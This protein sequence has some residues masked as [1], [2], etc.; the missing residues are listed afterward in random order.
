MCKTHFCLKYFLVLGSLLK[1]ELLFCR[2]L[3]KL[4]KKKK[5]T[6]TNSIGVY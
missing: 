6:S 1:T 4:R 5:Q 3:L 2:E